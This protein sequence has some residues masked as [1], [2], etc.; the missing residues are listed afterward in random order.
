MYVCGCPCYL[1]FTFVFTDSST[2]S[3]IIL[4]KK[5]DRYVLAY[6]CQLIRNWNLDLF[7]T[8]LSLSAGSEVDYSEYVLGEGFSGVRGGILG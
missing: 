8:V 7:S 4:A 3:N 5:K 1:Q 2:G 6:T